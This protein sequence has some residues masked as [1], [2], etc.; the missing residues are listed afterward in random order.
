MQ[1]INIPEEWRPVAGYEGFYDVSSLGWVRR[2][3][4]KRLRRQTKS[5]G[6]LTVM[7]CRDGVST[8][9][10][11]HRIVAETFLDRPSWAQCVRHLDG[12]L[13]NNTIWNL[14]W[15][16]NSENMMDRIAHG[17]DINAAKTHCLS[18]HPFDERN[19]YIRPTGQRSCRACG[20]DAQRR[21]QA[22]KNQRSIA[23]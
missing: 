4:G 17:N 11:I 10:P 3:G 9:K 23:E 22:R 7:L 18:G 1:P 13:D 19:T 5:G 8:N 20:R 12:D 6:Y 2:V 16:T 15:G 21:F 14:R